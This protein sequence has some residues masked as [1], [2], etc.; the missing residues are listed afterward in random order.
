MRIYPLMS[1]VRCQIASFAWPAH[2]KLDLF[3]FDPLLKSKKPW[4]AGDSSPIQMSS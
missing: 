2:R 1:A 4:I 3:Y